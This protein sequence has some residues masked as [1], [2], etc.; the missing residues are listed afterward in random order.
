MTLL[1]KSDLTDANNTSSTMLSN[2]INDQEDAQ[3]MINAIQEFISSSSSQLK[4]EAYDAVRAHMETYIPILQMRMKVAASLVE[5]IQ[6]ANSTMIDYMEDETVLDTAELDRLHYEYSCYTDSAQRSLNSA[7]V[8]VTQE[9]K[10]EA[11]KEYEFYAG[12]ARK[13]SK[14][15]QLLENLAAKDDSTYTQLCGVEAELTTYKNAIGDIDTIRYTT[16]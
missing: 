4:G 3:E 8:Y 15:I 11:M 7:N 9:A 12:E 1:K 6:S 5:S 14:K 16:K 10:S 2:L 13:L